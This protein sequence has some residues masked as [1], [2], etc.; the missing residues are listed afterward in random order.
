M[1]SKNPHTNISYTG[2]L[3]CGFFILYFT[4]EHMFVIITKNSPIYHVLYFNEVLHYD[5]RYEYSLYI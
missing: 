4:I 5:T 2:M 3:I 1:T